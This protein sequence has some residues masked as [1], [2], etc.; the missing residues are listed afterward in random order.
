MTLD[1]AVKAVD[2]IFEAVGGTVYLFG[3]AQSDDEVARVTAH[4]REIKNVR[5][6]VDHMMLK[7][8]DARRALQ[9]ALAKENQGGDSDG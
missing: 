1:S 8:S 6:I 4:A 7:N 2:S 9:K 3:V 5:R